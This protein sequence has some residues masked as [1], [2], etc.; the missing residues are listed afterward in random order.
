MQKRFGSPPSDSYVVAIDALQNSFF[1]LQAEIGQQF[2]PTIAQTAN[3]LATFFDA[4]RENNLGELPAPIQA[5]VQGAQSL[6]NALVSVGETIARHIGPELEGLLPALGGVLGSVLDLAGALVNALRPAYDLIAPILRVQIALVVKLAED[7][8]AL[9][10]GI[11]DFVNWLTGASREQETFNTTTQQTAATVQNATTAVQNAGQMTGEYAGNIQSLQSEL[12]R[13]NTELDAKRQRLDELSQTATST[14]HPAVQQLTRQVAELETQSASLTGQ[15]GTL[16]EEFTSI[17]APAMGAETATRGFVSSIDDFGGA[18][19]RIDTRFL[20]F[21]ERTEALSGAIRELPPELTAVRT[22]FDVLAPTAAR[23]AAVFKD[24]ETSVVDLEEEERALNLINSELH[25]GLTTTAEALQLTAH[26]ANLVN[27]AIS[28]GVESF[29]NYANIIGDVNLAYDDIIPATQDFVDG[30]V[31]QET[32]FDDLR[33]ATE[34]ADI[35]LDALDTTFNKIP[36]TVDTTAIAFADFGEDAIEVVDNIVRSF[37]PLFD[38]LGDVGGELSNF[39]TLITSLATG[40][41]LGIISSTANIILPGLTDPQRIL[42]FQQPVGEGFDPQQLQEQVGLTPIQLQQLDFSG[43]APGLLA[44]LGAGDPAFNVFQARSRTQDARALAE[45]TGTDRQAIED[46]ARAQYGAEAFDAE[47]AA[48]TADNTQALQENTQATM[49]AAGMGSDPTQRAILDTSLLQNQLQRAQFDL[50]LATDEDDFEARRQ[51]LISAT[52]TFYDAELQRIM[53]VAESETEL[54]DLREDNELARDRALQ[55]ATTATNTFTEARLRGEREVQEEAARTAEQQQREAQRLAEQQA[56]ETERQMREAE[57]MAEQQ[58]REQERAQQQAQR[59]TER[60][61]REAERQAEQEAREA[62]RQAERQSAAGAGLLQTGVRRAQFGLG[63]STSETDFEARRDV[64]ISATNAYYDNEEARIDGLMLSEIELQNLREANALAREQA[65][66]R[67]ADTEN[68]FEQQRLRDAEQAQREAERA[69]EQQR[70]EQERADAETLREA[71]RQQREQT[72][73]AEREERERMRAAEQA[74]REQQRLLERQQREEQRAIETRLRQEMRLYDAIAGLQDDRLDAEQEHADEI[75][76]INQR[77]QDRITDIQQRALRQRQDNERRANRSLE[78]L[79]IDFSRDIEDVLRGAGADDA[80][81]RSGDFQRILRTAE[82]GDQNRLRQ[83]LSQAGIRVSDEDLG[84]IGELGR[85]RQRDIADIQRD[86]ANRLSEIQIT[87]DRAI[88]DAEQ[89]RADALIASQDALALEQVTLTAEIA[90]LN[91]TLSEL[92]I[93]GGGTGMMGSGDPFA[94]ILGILGITG[95]VTRE[96]LS[97]YIGSRFTDGGFSDVGTLFGG[98]NVQALSAL[99]SSVLFQDDNV[100][101]R[102]TQPFTE[103]VA[104][105][106]IEAATP[107]LSAGGAEGGLM[108]AQAETPFNFENAEFVI[109]RAD[110]TIEQIDTINGGRGLPVQVQSG[111]VEVTKQPNQNVM[112][113]REKVGQVVGD[114]IRSQQQSGDSLL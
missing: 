83:F 60:Q 15:I 88:N 27:P 82:G 1:L 74:Q 62:E 22:E 32:A 91:T 43:V 10:G 78:D 111:Q 34:A 86:R 84:R 40:N 98:S 107:F 67:A 9:I 37:D 31:R 99:Q 54:Q 8:G 2:L 42:D 26:N 33:E 30:L 96:E 41:V 55:R 11:A 21:H 80:L 70:R 18:L 77:L 61:Q 104:A 5:I 19:T 92:E 49:D 63:F 110:I 58:R 38:V 3:A 36:D 102:P 39:T 57:R 59:E 7:V 14:A 20:T 114:A 64:L 94:T 87:Q 106:F 47:F 79:Q 4:I 69:A 44:L 68:P 72:R 100:R 35:S 17:E 97:S 45:A 56:R 90:A 13:V 29:R 103:E 12:T 65:L 28:Q 105:E 48:A 93:G 101:A 85:E 95:G 6:F 52:N 81:F 23:V 113:D 108:F 89:N 25:G 112:I 66:A 46:V 76:D 73:I 16:R 53:Q 71:E 75:I 51:R 109:N 50:G 24:I